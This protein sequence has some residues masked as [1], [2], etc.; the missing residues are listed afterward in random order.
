MMYT[1]YRPVISQTP[2]W[3]DN[4]DIAVKDL[5]DR[6]KVLEEE[7]RELKNERQG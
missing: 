4:V 1:G 7:L 5:L 2:D 6:V 3:E